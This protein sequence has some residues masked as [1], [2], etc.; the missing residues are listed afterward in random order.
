[1]SDINMNEDMLS[2]YVDGELDFNDR[3]AVEEQLA[4]SPEWR[5]VLFEITAVRNALRNLP[6]RD[7][8]PGFWESLDETAAVVDIETQRSLKKRRTRWVTAVGG[9]AVAAA[10]I[11]GIVVVPRTENS[12]PP[13]GIFSNRH[14][15][16]ASKGGSPIV[17]LASVATQNRF[18][19]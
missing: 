17:N 19:R 15:A 1:M 11:I 5:E 9:A 3:R 2:A 10:L 16:Q 7:A 18:S 14:A 8:P 4:A 13:V 6:E 12:P